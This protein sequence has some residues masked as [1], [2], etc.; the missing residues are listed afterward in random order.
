MLVPKLPYSERSFVDSFSD[1]WI[2]A[3]DLDL[4]IPNLAD[5]GLIADGA[6]IRDY[7][8]SA[9][10]QVLPAIVASQHAQRQRNSAAGGS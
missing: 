10:S 2:P 5:D 3:E 8:D 9:V 1:C 7:F 6:R 4:D